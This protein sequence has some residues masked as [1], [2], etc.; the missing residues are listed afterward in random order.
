MTYRSQ[1]SVR[2]YTP[3]DPAVATPVQPA[4]APGPLSVVAPA[5]DLGLATITLFVAGDVLI[6]SRIQNLVIQRR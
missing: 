2:S 3:V 4:V 1:F 6:T 5:L